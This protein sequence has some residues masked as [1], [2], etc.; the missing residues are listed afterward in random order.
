M[1]SDSTESLKGILFL[2]LDLYNSCLYFASFLK[3]SIP[4]NLK[5]FHFYVM[6][7]CK[8]FQK[9]FFFCSFLFLN[10]V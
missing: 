7:N 10:F 2:I 8:L 1:D 3:N 9:A 5:R 4:E 6:F